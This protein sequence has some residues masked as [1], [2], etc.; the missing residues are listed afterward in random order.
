M[1][2]EPLKL[3]RMIRL[4]IANIVRLFTLY[5]VTT[6]TP[7]CAIEFLVYLDPHGYAILHR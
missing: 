5:A 4:P 2:D 6:N 7:L 3:L 1:I